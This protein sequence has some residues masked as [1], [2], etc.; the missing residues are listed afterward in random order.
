M[1][2][3]EK[4]VNERV[5][6]LE[7]KLQDMELLRDDENRRCDGLEH[8]LKDVHEAKDLLLSGDGVD[9][10]GHSFDEYV[11]DYRT[12]RARANDPGMNV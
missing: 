6:D 1:G 9:I 7:D 5:K 8:E 10:T 3:A 12:T 4:M 11:K 2:V